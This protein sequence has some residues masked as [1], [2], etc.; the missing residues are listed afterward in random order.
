[1]TSVE[2]W[3]TTTGRCLV[4]CVFIIVSGWCIVTCAASRVTPLKCLSPAPGVIYSQLHIFG[5]VNHQHNV[6]RKRQTRAHILYPSLASA[7]VVARA[8]ASPQSIFIGSCDFII[9]PRVTLPPGVRFHLQA[10]ALLA[11]ASFFICRTGGGGEGNGCCLATGGRE[12][13]DSHKNR[14]LNV[15]RLTNSGG[16]PPPPLLHKGG[17]SRTSRVVELVWLFFVL[18]FCFEGVTVHCNAVRRI[19][20]KTFVNNIF[21]KKK[22]QNMCTNWM[23][24][25]VSWRHGAFTVLPSICDFVC[26]PA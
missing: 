9:Q 14:L 13:S 12:L 20:Q 8:H 3:K 22:N 26:Y 7:N 11:S 4:F 15:I 16:K 18:F 5:W 21:T 25:C 19:T 24:C 23:T 17:R 2:F 6:H 1:M 10:A